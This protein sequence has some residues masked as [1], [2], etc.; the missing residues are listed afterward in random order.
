MD[1]TSWRRLIGG[2]FKQTMERAHVMM[3]HGISISHNTR[4]RYGGEIKICKKHTD[5]NVD[6]PMMKR[7]QHKNEAHEI[8][9]Y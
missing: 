9:G 6:D 3:T 1:S 5:L 4:V 2:L 8:Y 7:P